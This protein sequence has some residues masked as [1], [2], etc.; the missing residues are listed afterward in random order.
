MNSTNQ[1]FRITDLIKKIGTYKHEIENEENK[2]YDYL[3]RVFQKLKF[4]LESEIFRNRAELD[5]ED[6]EMLKKT[7]LDLYNENIILDK[8]ITFKETES[9]NYL[10]AFIEPCGDFIEEDSF[11]WVEDSYLLCCY[12]LY[13][14]KAYNDWSKYLGKYY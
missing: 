11:K 13:R 10:M 1:V 2:K 6:N 5:N 9:E 12:N 7:I 8:E 4:E 3:N 14:T